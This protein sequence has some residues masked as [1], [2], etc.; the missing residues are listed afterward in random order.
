M[1]KKGP[2][3]SFSDRA[4]AVWNKV[5]FQMFIPNISNLNGYDI[6]SHIAATNNDVDLEKIVCLIWCIW[7]ER[8]KELHGTKLKPADIICIFSASHLDQYHKA[9]LSTV[10]QNSNTS[11]PPD[12]HT[13]SHTTP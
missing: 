3:L 1:P 7:H 13:A 12:P 6:F 4:K 11:K 2:H 8:N 5:Q 9:T 10:I